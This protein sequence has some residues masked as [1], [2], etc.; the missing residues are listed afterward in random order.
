MSINRALPSIR[1]DVAAIYAASDHAALRALYESLIGEWSEDD[2]SD[3]Q[4]PDYLREH[5]LDYMRE[6]CS[7]SGTHVLDAGIRPDD[8]SPP[9]PVGEVLE[10]PAPGV[11]EAMQMLGELDAYLRAIRA[12]E[13][14]GSEPALGELLDRSLAL[15]MR[16]NA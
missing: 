7:A 14:D 6:L 11:H 8:A 3:L 10:A 16:H 1:A 12:E 4:H 13:L 2:C 15:R 5:L 9:I